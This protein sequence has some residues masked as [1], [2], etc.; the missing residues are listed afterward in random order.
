MAG[1]SDRKDVKYT[2]LGTQE[3]DRKTW[4][5]NN[6]DIVSSPYS[7]KKQVNNTFKKYLAL[8]SEDT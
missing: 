1:E 5:V 8:Q 3:S 7:K 6:Q 2:G 4:H